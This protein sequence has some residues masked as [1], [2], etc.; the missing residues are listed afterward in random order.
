MRNDASKT[1]RRPWRV[2]AL[3]AAVLLATAGPKA[4]AFACGYENPSA[5]A[6]G[7]LNWVFPNAL[8]VRSAVWRAEKAGILPRPL[9]AGPAKGLFG[10]GFRR[11]AASMAR[12]GE[13]MHTA[14]LTTGK[15]PSFAVVLIP[16]VMWTTYA[17]SPRGYVVRVHAEGPAKGDVVIVTDEKVV[18]ALVDGSLDALSAERLGLV[19][20]Y[21]PAGEVRAAL[22]ALP[23]VGSGPD[24]VSALPTGDPGPRY[25][26]YAVQK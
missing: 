16:A 15:A 22:A 18:R 13:R 11:A 17:P 1:R 6:L 3:A 7:M 2:G 19:R 25:S 14:A 5:L 4:S 21:G 20:F 23:A 9:P 10:S 12:L 26:P 8:Y 24:S